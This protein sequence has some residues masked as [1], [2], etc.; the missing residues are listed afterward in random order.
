MRSYDRYGQ[1]VFESDDLNFGWDGTHQ[2][3]ALPAGTFVYR[4]EYTEA[5]RQKGQR[6]G[7]LHLIR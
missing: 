6:Y 3:Q 5:S 1:V 7:L 2:G 4:L